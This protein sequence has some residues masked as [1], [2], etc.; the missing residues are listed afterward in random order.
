MNTGLMNLKIRKG[1]LAWLVLAVLGALLA[2]TPTQNIRAD[3]NIVVNTDQDNENGDD[4]LCTLRE[5]IN[6]ANADADTTNGD[7][8]AGTGTDTIT[9]DGDY[10][11]VLTEDLP[12]VTTKIA[13]GNEPYTV[14]VDGDG[15]YLIF[16]V[17]GTLTNEGDLII[18][19]LIIQNGG[20]D[21]GAAIMNS[22]GVFTL[23]NSVVQNIGNPNG[24]APIVNLSGEMQ[25]SGSMFQ[26]NNSEIAGA[27]LN[28][29]YLAISTSTFKNNV[30]DVSGVIFNGRDL[31]VSNST[32]FNNTGDAAAIRSFGGS[33]IVN[34]TTFNGNNGTATIVASAGCFSE[35][36][37]VLMAD[38]GTKSI[39]DIDVGDMVL[40]FDFTTGRQV[41][42]RVTDVM[43]RPARSFLR[44]N[45]LEVTPEHPFA[46]GEDE[47]RVA[48]SLKVGDRS[49]SQ[50]G[51]TTITSISSVEEQVQVYNITVDSTH[52]YY[53]SDAEDTYL[54]HNK[55]MLD[56]NEF[57]ITNS[58]IT[59]SSSQDCRNDGGTFSG[60]NNLIDD[61][62][63]G[64][65]MDLSDAAVTNLDAT[66]ADN[67]GPT[68]TFALL[69]GSN[70]ID[71][72]DPATCEATDQRSVAR[73][74]G[75]GCDIGAFELEGFFNFDGFFSPISNLPMVNEMKAGRSLPLKFSLDGDQGLD[76]IAIGYPK[77]QST[78]CS[79]G[80]LVDPVEETD[81][82]GQSG[83]SYDPDS[84][85][86]TYVWKTKKSWANKCGTLTLELSDGSQHTAE[87]K[88]VK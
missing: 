42:S 34:N 78:A 82:A 71:A 58:I 75:D 85:T 4:G 65:C 43:S 33:A 21:F 29:G 40:S 73:P 62:D 19:N 76:I 6:N 88:F 67:G 59:N 17:D 49:L 46:V 64:A 20:G 12:P 24:G 54:V 8:V 68:Q 32:F 23:K 53:V 44:I 25:I 3:S 30:G 1:L 63:S 9:F 5:A 22:S 81:T 70:A 61:H 7:C 10:T 84:D 37:Q 56:N 83:L 77:F 45:G 27:I 47:W 11:I 57:R 13:I 79:T 69:P 35:N 36:A 86:Y 26:F 66:L 39:A 28:D 48:G 2:G 41:A 18:N 87:F 72:G 60:S 51:W 38:G 50:G 31:T 80:D 52:N 74:Q 15:P 55:T 16:G 14:T